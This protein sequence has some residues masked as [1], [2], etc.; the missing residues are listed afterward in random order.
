[1]YI[2]I[3]PMIAAKPKATV[4]RRSS[5]GGNVPGIPA[6][7]EVD[8]STRMLTTPTTPRTKIIPR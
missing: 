4:I 8:V 3:I 2:A 6:N 1:M 5:E 7:P